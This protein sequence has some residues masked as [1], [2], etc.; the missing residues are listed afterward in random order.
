MYK[1]QAYSAHWL[2]CHIEAQTVEI[3]KDWSAHELVSYGM[4]WNTQFLSNTTQVSTGDIVYLSYLNIID[5]V[6]VTRKYIFNSTELT[7]I[8]DIN[9]MYSN[10][11]CQVY[12]V[13]SG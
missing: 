13:P 2:C 12:I 10:G 3:Y 4:L 1:R 9:L 5:G 8:S 6:V 11:G 7:F